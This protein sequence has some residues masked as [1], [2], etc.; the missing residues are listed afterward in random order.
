MGTVEVTQF[1]ERPSKRHK[2]ITLK[3]GRILEKSGSSFSFSSILSIK[4][5]FIY[6]T[7][8]LFRTMHNHKKCVCE[9][10]QGAWCQPLSKGI[11]VHRLRPW[12]CS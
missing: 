1:L 7:Y 2:R 4:N 8:S 6:F 5:V 9:A 10:S 11:V 12:L 3:L